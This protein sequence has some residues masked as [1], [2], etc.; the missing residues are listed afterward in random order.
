MKKLITSVLFIIALSS[1]L[2]S[3]SAQSN[4]DE[5][6]GYIV[7]LK[8]IPDIVSLAESNAENEISIINEEH[9]LVQVNKIDDLPSYISQND[10]EYIEPN[11]T[12][13]LC[14]IPAPNDQYASAWFM[15]NIKA[16]KA[17]ETGCHGE[18]ILIGVI[19]SGVSK[20]KDIT[21]NLMQG[22]NV[23]DDSTD[24]T[25][26]TGHG[27]FVSGIIA[28]QANNSFACAG[29]AYNAKIVPLKCFEGATTQT[30]YLVSAIYKAVDTYN[31]KIIN[32]SAGTS[33]PS[34]SLQE[35]V[36][37]ATDKGTIIVAASGN[38]GNKDQNG[39]V[40][41]NTPNYPAAYD[42]VVSV[43]AVDENNN[44]ASFSNYDEYV[45]VVAP[46]KDVISLYIENDESLAAY[47]DGTS[48]AAPF[49]TA[50]AAICLNMSPNITP[51]EFIE[52]LK[53][54]STDLG[55]TGRDDFYGYGL[56]NMEKI[57]EYLL[58]DKDYFV[59]PFD[60][61]SSTPSAV[62]Y[63]NTD[64]EQSL[65]SI[66]KQNSDFSL[67]KIQ[68]NSKHGTAIYFTPTQENFTHFLWGLNLKPLQTNTYSTPN[69]SH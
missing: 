38:H 24:T 68:T 21:K 30:S 47:S 37:Y 20:H 59:S 9:N 29:L 27:T 58:K 17:W 22:Y 46:G 63:N 61:E 8:S 44:I 52:I 55:E 60:F 57:T 3:A 18:N 23:T 25:D 41:I 2:V 39:K 10:I 14:D 67:K 43:G 42:C 53:Q 4:I 65:L 6:N 15:T 56:L 31:C 19:D 54:T 51:A 26:S 13:Y 49:V 69:T 11:H 7:K 36:E 64:S 62:V 50:A 33:K 16:S 66:W 40:I 28:A 12:V 48:F 1:I 45:T 5:E 34:Q 32:I 35:A